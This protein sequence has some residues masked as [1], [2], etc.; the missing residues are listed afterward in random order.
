M[1]CGVWVPVVADPGCGEGLQ[2]PSPEAACY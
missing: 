1:R 2:V